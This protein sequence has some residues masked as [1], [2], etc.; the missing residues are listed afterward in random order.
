M[1]IANWFHWK[2]RKQLRQ[3]QFEKLKIRICLKDNVID[4]KEINHNC[5]IKL[6]HSQHLS[7]ERLVSNNLKLSL[8]YAQTVLKKRFV[9]GEK[10]ISTDAIFSYFYALDVVKGRFRKGEKA[11]SKSPE[12]SYLYALNVLEEKRFKLGEYNITNNDRFSYYYAKH[13]L[14]GRFLEYERKSLEYRHSYYAE[15]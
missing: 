3:Q 11:I 14:K 2:H 13:I 4:F 9:L 15:L 1:K 7:V 8:E 6:L 10:I 5:L 12:Y